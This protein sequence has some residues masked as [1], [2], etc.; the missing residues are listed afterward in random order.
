MIALIAFLCG[1]LFALGLGISGMT[2]PAKVLGFLDVGGSWD[3]SLAFVMIGAIAVHAVLLPIILRR[4]HPLLAPV[5]ALPTRRDIDA[6]L[7]AGAAIFGVGWGLAGLCPGPAVTV[8]ASGGML[9]IAFVLAMLAG[10]RAARPLA[11]AFTRR[12]P[13]WLAQ[14]GAQKP[15]R[16][17][18]G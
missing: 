17:S 9:P 1:V 5:F 14:P 7:L 8:L 13:R 16:T 6:P 15:S 2:R 3:P 10:M 4:A 18:A 11:D 12:P